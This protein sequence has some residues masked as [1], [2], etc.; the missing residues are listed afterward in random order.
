MRYFWQSLAFS[1]SVRW[2]S[3]EGGSP[4]RLPYCL[5]DDVKGYGIRFLALLIDPVL[6]HQMYP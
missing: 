3:I 2:P 6:G 1:S 5:L 4:V